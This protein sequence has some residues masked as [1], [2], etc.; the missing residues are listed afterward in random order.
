MLEMQYIA[1]PAPYIETLILG[2]AIHPEKKAIMLL[3]CSR[4]NIIAFLLV[5]K[6]VFLRENKVRCVI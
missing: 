5:H 4:S 2:V 1:S 6:E 3:Y